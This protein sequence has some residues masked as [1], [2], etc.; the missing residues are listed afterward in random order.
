M[1]RQC[2]CQRPL[3]CRAT[4]ARTHQVPAYAYARKGKCQEALAEAEEGLMPSG[5]SLQGKGDDPGVP[6]RNLKRVEF[7]AI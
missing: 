6:N 1:F 7:N 5:G 2:S 4:P 3:Q